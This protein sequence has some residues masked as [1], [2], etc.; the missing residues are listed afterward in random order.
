RRALPPPVPARLEE[1]QEGLADVRAGPG[2]L[3][4]LRL[5]H[6]GGKIRKSLPLVTP[7]HTGL[8][9][10]SLKEGPN[11]RAAQLEG[12]RQRESGAIR[13]DGLDLLAHRVELPLPAEVGDELERTRD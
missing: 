2:D 9:E 1:A 12:K 13:V 11:F 4:L 7:E 10:R 8:S 5:R 3:L 6:G